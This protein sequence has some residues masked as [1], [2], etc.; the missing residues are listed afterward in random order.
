MPK[1]DVKNDQILVSLSGDPVEPEPLRQVYRAF[2]TG[3]K[4]SVLDPVK[5][6]V[7]GRRVWI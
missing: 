7:L 1:Y 4:L 5:T 2:A 3:I 6:G